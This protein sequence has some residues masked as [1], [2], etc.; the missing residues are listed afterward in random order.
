M[1]GRRRRLVFGN[2]IFQA[3]G[4]LARLKDLSATLC[5]GPS[6]ANNMEKAFQDMWDSRLSDG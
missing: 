2:V 3:F 6:F 1:V 4:D 5:D